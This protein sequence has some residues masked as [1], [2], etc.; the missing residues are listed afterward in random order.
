MAP[1]SLQ[2]ARGDPWGQVEALC[3][4]LGLTPLLGRHGPRKSLVPGTSLS[5]PRQPWAELSVGPWQGLAVTP[6]SKRSQDLGHLCT[7][8]WVFCSLRV[9]RMF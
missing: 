5:W 1:R 8:F 4:Q 9:T 6:L 2:A 3:L 7:L